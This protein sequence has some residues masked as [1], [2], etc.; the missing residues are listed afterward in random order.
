MNSQ[1]L[2]FT[3]TTSSPAGFK[4]TNQRAQLRLL[5]SNISMFLLNQEK[6]RNLLWSV[7]S[8][9]YKKHKST[10]RIGINSNDNKLG[11]V[12]QKMRTLR[13]PLA[14]YLYLQGVTNQVLKIDFYIDIDKEYEIIKKIY[15]LID[16]VST[17]QS[18]NQKTEDGVENIDL[19]K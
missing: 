8:L 15:N 2:H 16:K 11:T 6:L 18:T 5:L 17:N 10:L 7:K 14:E 4:K 13:K 3:N 9:D 1:F 12:L 19:L